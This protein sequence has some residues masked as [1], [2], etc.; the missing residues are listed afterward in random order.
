VHGGYTRVWLFFAIRT[1]VV[2]PMKTSGYFRPLPETQHLWDELAA[3]KLAGDRNRV[4]ALT[5][6]IRRASMEVRRAAGQHPAAN[7]DK[8]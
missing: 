6:Q 5:D 2:W 4:S 8:K 1:D 3:A 7:S